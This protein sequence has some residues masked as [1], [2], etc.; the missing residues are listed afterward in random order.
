MVG[1]VVEQIAEDGPQKLGLRIVRR[2]QLVEPLD[3]ILDRENRRDFIGRLGVA[4]GVILL[5]K[6]QYQNIFAALG[7]DAGAGLLTERTFGDQCR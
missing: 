3:W 7:I 6:I 2:T 5:G 1:T 4:G